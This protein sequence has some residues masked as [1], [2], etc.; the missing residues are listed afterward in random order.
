[1]TGT[2][3]SVV[4][5]LRKHQEAGLAVLA[6][7]GLYLTS[8]HSYLLFHSAAELFSIVV[9][10]TIFVVA[11]NARGMYDNAYLLL[12]GVAYLFVGGVDLIHT[13]AYKGMGVFPGYDA[14]LPTQLWIAARG[15]EAVSL[16]VAPLLLGRRLNA[17]LLFVAY[18]AV[19][20]LLL[21]SI[22]VWP[23]FPVCYVD[24]VGGGL[25]R[26]KVVSEYVIS[27]TLVA[28]LVLLW[29]RRGQF[30]PSVLRLLTAAVA[31]TIASELAFTA[32]V[33]VFGTASLI[34][35]LLKVASFYL[36]YKAI[37]Q[38][39][40]VKPYSLL[41]RE[42]SH[43]EAELRAA[44]QMQEQM[45]YFIVHDLRSPLTSVLAGIEALR[46]SRGKELSGT[47]KELVDAAL[48]SSSWMLTLTDSLLDSVRL[49]SG[50]MPLRVSEVRVRDLID[51][52]LA[53][54]SA[55]AG[56]CRVRLD[57]RLE[58]EGLAV[59]ADRDVT[60]RILV[61]LLS[62]A[63]K[64]SP[65]DSTIQI[66]AAPSGADAIAFTVADQGPGI[67]A[68]WADKVFERFGQVEARQA[69]AAGAGLGLAFCRLAVEAQ[70]GR[71]RLSSSVG[72]GATVVF[73]LPASGVNI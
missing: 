53:H 55:W 51:S 47:D 39:A 52:S 3:A 21:A 29:L 7:A 23:I 41:F 14:N 42:L 66:S 46:T 30:D 65:V 9:A 25:T 26:F 13:L 57:A 60:I 62:N 49:E 69:G 22:F 12:I 44:Q 38:T 68:E 10:A 70:G 20:S 59:A 72:E 18:A 32:Y 6:L 73:T 35:H 28:A 4:R 1:M 54:V 48:S 61:N 56:L 40:L 36:V 11:W 71:I 34:G 5:V 58:T 50:K 33:S 63:I 16:L 15:L 45:T 2:T 17:N 31:L 67:P 8:R 24:W 27:A 43:R 19:T 64:H 37:V